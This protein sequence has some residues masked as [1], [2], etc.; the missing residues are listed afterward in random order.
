LLLIYAIA[1]GM[2]TTTQQHLFN[3]SGLGMEYSAII[4]NLVMLGVTPMQ[5]GV[6]EEGEE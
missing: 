6:E 4:Q 2:D 1:R 5:V 3:V